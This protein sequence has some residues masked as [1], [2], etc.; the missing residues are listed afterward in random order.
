MKTVALF[1]A[2]ILGCATVGP[3]WDAGKVCVT[4]AA[5]NSVQTVLPKLYDVLAC[6]IASGGQAIPACALAGVEQVAA[7][8]GEDVLLCA[9]AEISN[10]KG[11][12]GSERDVV[13]KRAKA[14]LEQRT[15]K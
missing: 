8:F 11:A 7:E 13:A 10:R 9:L 15:A 6:S 5:K 12:P 1:L 4:E 2:I 3:V 14:V